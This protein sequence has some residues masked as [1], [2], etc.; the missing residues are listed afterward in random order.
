[1]IPLAEERPFQ[2]VE[3]EKIISNHD[4]E[5]VRILCA[6]L[7]D[8]KGSL[9]RQL[10]SLNKSLEDIKC[11]SPNWRKE[12]AKRKRPAKLSLSKFRQLLGV[13]F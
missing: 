9:K 6:E 2:K 7:R 1:M 4:F 10:E 3:E 11:T 12:Q 8:D 5:I 13:L